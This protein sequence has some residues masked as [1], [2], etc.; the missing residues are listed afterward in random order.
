MTATI[1]PTN[2]L[3]DFLALFFGERNGF[4]LEKMYNPENGQS[5]IK[6]WVDRLL[7][8]QFTILPFWHR[9]NDVIWFGIAFSE[10]QW[11]FLA[12]QVKNFFG[13]TYSDFSGMR[14]HPVK[15]EVDEVV[16]V[17]TDGRYIRFRADPAHMWKMLDRVQEVWNAIPNRMTDTPRT[18]GRVLRD[19]FM[20]LEAHNEGNAWLQYRLLE[21][22]NELGA[23]NLLFLQV[24]LLAVFHKWAEILKLV[25]LKDLLRIRRPQY[26][27]EI[28]IQAA[29]REELDDCLE[30]PDR[31]VER[32]QD[33]LLPRYG[34]LLRYRGNMSRSETLLAFMLLAVS[35]TD[36]TAVRD[37]LKVH[38]DTTTRQLLQSVADP[39]L[40]LQGL[41]VPP[42]LTNLVEAIRQYMDR[43]RFDLAL[44]A[45]AQLSVGTQQVKF[46][47]ECAYE[48]AAKDLQQ[49][50]LDA[51]NTLSEEDRNS[52]L[53]F[54]RI[55]EYIAFLQ[56]DSGENIIPPADWNA[57][58][59]TL[60]NRG[61][62]QNVDTARLGAAEWQVESW[63]LQE[64]KVQI[65]LNTLHEA[66]RDESRKELLDCIF[67]FFLQYLKRDAQHPRRELAEL[68]VGM[69]EWL[70]QLSSGNADDITL[71]SETGLLLM[72]YPLT[73]D[74]YRRMLHAAGHMLARCRGQETA[75]SVTPFIDKIAT[76]PAGD[77]L[78]RLRFFYQI[79]QSPLFAH[80]SN[81]TKN[82]AEGLLPST[83]SAWMDI[84]Q[85]GS[86]D[87][88]LL[89]D[90]LKPLERAEYAEITWN[91]SVI[92][93]LNDQVLEW[94]T[95][96]K[97]VSEKGVFSVA[98]LQ[99]SYWVA[100]DPE[101]PR[102]AFHDL[103]E[104]LLFAVSSDHQRNLTIGKALF[105]L[106]EGLLRLDSTK[107]MMLW[108]DLEPWLLMQPVPRFSTLILDC[109][110]L[111]EDFG[112]PALE[113]REV[114]NHWMSY[115]IRHP[116]TSVETD[117]SLWIAI[118]E[119]CS[120]DY[121]LLTELQKLL[122]EAE[123]TDRSIEELPSYKIA[124]FSC[125]EKAARRAAKRIMDRNASLDVRVCTHDRLTEQAKSL[126]MEADLVIVVTACISHALTYGIM[127]QL[128]QRPLYPRSSGE[129]G[130]VSRLEQYAL[131]GA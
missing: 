57:W 3:Q 1:S 84:R 108:K 93:G 58:F 43:G 17:L 95:D 27:T 128:R 129:A 94:V 80:F 21:Q 16:N 9:G 11:Q 35:E 5:R 69:F 49:Q 111:F 36:Q 104:T 97:S 52:L 2:D 115:L 4:S 78:E 70:S 20:A 22:R 101:F 8:K 118:G 46:L 24:N 110:E 88:K 75:H 122:S 87:T 81:N 34:H 6:P 131:E 38:T 91:H 105:V 79:R 54:R 39:L 62:Q 66:L 107:N 19:Y 90:F 26:I 64:A 44:P 127:P 45:I 30:E 50:A 71:W 23:N 47:L 113:L 42:V 121:T 15:H 103:Y 72:R 102:P 119:T 65:F 18:L 125:R 59:A 98:M 28:L 76:E 13:P 14:A 7:Q 124:I 33:R 68:Y 89:L 32:F 99:L 100:G 55:R 25:Q 96:E 120:A 61:F 60:K 48:L 83:W 63:L 29:V 41:V 82:L 86:A 51:F 56:E 123:E 109:L 67:P 10:Q 130:I 73:E 40:S 31:M 85:Q 92:S 112:L 106:N 12:E 74:R 114:W 117:L 53:T 126:S 116:N 37:L 77:E